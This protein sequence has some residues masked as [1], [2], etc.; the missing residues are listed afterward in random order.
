[1]RNIAFLLM[2]ML[3]GNVCF[4]QENVKKRQKTRT[5]QKTT[6]KQTQVQQKTITGVKTL[7]NRKI[8]I[9]AKSP[10]EIARE[11]AFNWLAPFKNYGNFYTPETIT[12]L[13]VLDLSTGSP[14]ING[15]ARTYYMCD[16]SLVHLKQFTGLKRLVTTTWMTNKGLDHIAGLHNLNALYMG[17]TNVNNAGLSK[18]A[19]LSHLETL[20]LFDTPI[21]NDGLEQI[22]QQFPGL[23]ILNIGSTPINDNGLVH[24]AK[25]PYLEN[26][27]LTRGNFTDNAVPH[28]LQLQN[29][30]LISVEFTQMTQSGKDQLRAAYPNATIID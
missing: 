11:K 13:S 21:T 17:K 2:L 19:N 25:L 24:L 9:P 14:I 30:K 10:E 4:A 8:V 16:D 23:K 7:S 26:L 15:V 27:I 3:L 29:L 6:K 1:M 20:V 28:I 18:I 5:I 12:T 22:A